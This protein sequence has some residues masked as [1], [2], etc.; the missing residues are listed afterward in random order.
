MAQL[1]YLQAQTAHSS[2]GEV[3]KGKHPDSGGQFV[4]HVQDHFELASQAVAW[5]FTG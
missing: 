3:C 1:D 2:S 5:H 4:Q